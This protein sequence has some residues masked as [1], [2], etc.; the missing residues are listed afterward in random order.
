MANNLK[1]P[2][3]SR[4]TWDETFMNLALLISKRAACRYHEVGAVFVDSN[5]R[6][7]SMGYNGPTEGDLHCLDK[8]VGCAKVDGNPIT[9]KLEKCRGAHAEING[10][11]NSQDTTRLRGAT[12]YCTNS[13]CYSCMKALNNAGI[14]EIIYFQEYRRIKPGGEGLEEELESKALA[15]RRG[16]KISKYSGQVYCDLGETY[17]DCANQSCCGNC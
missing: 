3:T 12:L 14:K 9:K 10:I 2:K 4:L 6:I 15:E 5:K 11:I 8:N 16:I 13:P 1:N 17:D 7:I